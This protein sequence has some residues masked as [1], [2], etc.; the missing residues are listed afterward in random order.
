MGTPYLLFG[1]RWQFLLLQMGWLPLLLLRVVLGT[2]LLSGTLALNSLLLTR[3]LL[4]L[5][6]VNL[7]PLAETM[8]WLPGNLMTLTSPLPRP[9]VPCC[10]NDIAVVESRGRKVRVVAALGT[11]WDV[12]WS[13]LET[14]LGRGVGVNDWDEL[15]GK[16]AG[17]VRRKCSCLGVR[18]RVGTRPLFPLGPPW[19]PHQLLNPVE[20]NLWPRCVTRVTE[21]D[22]GYLVR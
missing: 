7:P 20:R 5:L 16:K 3:P 6:F 4:C 15:L 9:P 17:D 22:P 8:A 18:K 13:W 21:T 10:K 14:A 2:W 19:Y 1:L 11:C 12:L